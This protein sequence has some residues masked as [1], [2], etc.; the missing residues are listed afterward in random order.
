MVATA[1]KCKPLGKESLLMRVQKAF[2]LLLNASRTERWVKCQRGKIL[3]TK[4]GW[5]KKK[6]AGGKDVGECPPYDR[7]GEREMRLGFADRCM[8]RLM[9]WRR[10]A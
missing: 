2:L 3:G 8:G 4:F 5:E 7:V 10:V 6:K 1:S 9:C